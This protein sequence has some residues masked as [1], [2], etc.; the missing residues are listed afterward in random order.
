ML[1]RD[2]APFARDI[3]DYL[4]VK[5]P[6]DEPATADSLSQEEKICFKMMNGLLYY[7]SVADSDDPAT[8]RLY[9]PSSLRHSYLVSSCFS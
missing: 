1:W 7:R 6:A 5:L 4:L 3:M 8:F 9:V 2:P